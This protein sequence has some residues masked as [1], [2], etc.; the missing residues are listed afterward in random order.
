MFFYE[1]GLKVLVFSRLS[2]EAT[3]YPTFFF[4]SFFFLSTIYKIH[5]I[6]VSGG[7]YWF[8]WAYFNEKSLLAL[9]QTFHTQLS[10]SQKFPIFRRPFT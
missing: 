5:V 6:L 3:L 9:D 1:I 10:L 2:F 7:F 4:L 8:P